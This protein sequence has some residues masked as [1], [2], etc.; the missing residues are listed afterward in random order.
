MSVSTATVT[1]YLTTDMY[2][3]ET[4]PVLIISAIVP[5]IFLLVKIYKAD[6]LEK[7]PVSLIL[8]LVILGIISTAIAIVLEE[9]GAV[10]AGA[11]FTE[12]SL[13]YNL[14][15]YYCVVA[16]AEEGA[17]YALLK[18]RTWKSKEFNFRFDGIVYAVCV[19]LGFALWENIGYVTMYGFETAMLRAVTAVPGHCCFGIFMGLWYGVAK[20]FDN[21]DKPL[22]SK[23]FRRKSLT[24]PIIIHGT[25]DFLTTLNL[26]Y[27]LFVPFVIII[28]I[29]AYRLVK[30]TSEHDVVISREEETQNNTY[31]YQ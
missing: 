4:N 30:E 15:F 21:K 6:K 19:S 7:E 23:K 24:L 14:F 26:L 18:M 10:V 3:L 28:F 5:A 9:V 11:V 8:S 1:V 20:Y 2:F 13:L 12:D 31:N 16:V 27:F 22:I 29:V 17:K 25:Y